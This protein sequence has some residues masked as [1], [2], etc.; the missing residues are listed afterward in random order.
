MNELENHNLRRQW[1]D[2]SVHRLR[3]EHVQ[4]TRPFS[5]SYVYESHMN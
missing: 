1:T 5:V 4:L 2:F 3:A